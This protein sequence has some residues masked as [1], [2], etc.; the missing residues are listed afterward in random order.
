MKIVREELNAHFQLPL[1][2]RFCIFERGKL[3]STKVGSFFIAIDYDVLIFSAQ[4]KWFRDG[5]NN[6]RSVKM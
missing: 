6:G 4:E 2:V 5:R 3:W 1:S